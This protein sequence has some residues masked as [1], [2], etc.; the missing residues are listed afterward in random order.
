MGVRAALLIALIPLMTGCGA[1]LASAPP[2]NPRISNQAGDPDAPT[3]PY[4]V[5]CDGPEHELRL[6]GGICGTKTDVYGSTTTD[7]PTG[8]GMAIG[9]LDGP[10]LMVFGRAEHEV[11]LGVDVSAEL[12]YS[13]YF[14]NRG[15]AENSAATLEQWSKGEPITS[16]SLITYQA[17]FGGCGFG[18]MGEGTLLW[19]T[20]TFSLAWWSG[21]GC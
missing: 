16:G 4:E 18:W 10:Y 17:S 13:A 15:R 20:T 2:V 19:R 11:A 9:P 3:L 8:M 7:A 1:D 5:R 21:V 14:V 6:L 12:G